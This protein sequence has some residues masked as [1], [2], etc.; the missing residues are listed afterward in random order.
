[1]DSLNYGELKLQNY[2]K[3]PNIS[4]AEAENLFRY[5]TRSAKFKQNM[6]NGYESI[7]CP[8]CLVHPDTQIHSMLCI[9]VK[10]K[11]LVKGN[12]QDIFKE[13]I[14]KEISETLM[15]I[16]EIRKDVL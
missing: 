12:Y 3:N 11:I 8:F 16:S 2:L 15:K 9:E 13:D 6:K 10:S 5:R 14:P 7:T 4:V 1:M